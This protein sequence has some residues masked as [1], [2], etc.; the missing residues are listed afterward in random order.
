MTRLRNMVII[1]IEIGADFLKMKNYV[2]YHL[3]PFRKSILPMS[4]AQKMSVTQIILSQISAE[5]CHVG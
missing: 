3:N 5:L 2:R 4:I 1:Q